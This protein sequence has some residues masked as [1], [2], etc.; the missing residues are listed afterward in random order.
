[1]IEYIKFFA[2]KLQHT[3]VHKAAYTD[4]IS[5]LEFLLANNADVN[6]LNSFGSTPLHYSTRKGNIQSSTVL[7]A[8][9]ADTDIAN[10]WKATPL[11]EA[12]TVGNPDQIILLLDHGANFTLVN[13]NGKTAQDLAPPATK[14][15]FDPNRFKKLKSARTALE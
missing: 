12:A 7:L 11:H 14:E 5:V 9:G 3:G 10:R 8:H 2:D 4:N 15:F 13:D 1:M 6:A